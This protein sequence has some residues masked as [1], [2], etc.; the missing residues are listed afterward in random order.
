MMAREVPTPRVAHD[1]ELLMT[2]IAAGRGDALEELY[3]RYCVSAYR[4]A[5]SVCGDPGHAEEAVQEAFISVWRS[6]AAYRSQRGTASAWLLTVVR[7]RAIDI[8]RRNGPHAA[9]RANDDW[10]DARPAPD[11]IADQAA[12]HADAAHLRGL[13][14]RLPEAQRRAITL[15]FYGELS[16]SEIAARLGLP[17]GTVKSRIRL[18]LHKLEADMRTSRA[19]AE[20]VALA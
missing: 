13:L 11:D 10:L 14:A 12:A 20:L 3:D 6:A 15:A 18:G 9:R 8:A 2:G 4:V 1:D 7:H 19:T 17:A 5:Q 16:H